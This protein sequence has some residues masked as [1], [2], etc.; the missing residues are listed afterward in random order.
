MSIQNV[1]FWCGILCAVHCITQVGFVTIILLY[2]LM[3]LLCFF[4]AFLAFMAEFHRMSQV[5]GGVGQAF[6]LENEEC[7]LIG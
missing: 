2:K 5:I 6:S 1:C 3:L 4:L 7:M